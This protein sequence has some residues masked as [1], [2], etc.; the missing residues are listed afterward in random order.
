MKGQRVGEAPLPVPTDT[1]LRL[2]QIRVS[3]TGRLNLQASQQ[4]RGCCQPQSLTL[5][6]RTRTARTHTHTHAV[7]ISSV[8][9]RCHQELNTGRHKPPDQQCPPPYQLELLLLSN[10]THTHKYQCVTPHSHSYIS[11]SWSVLSPHAL[12]GTQGG[13]ETSLSSS[14]LGFRA[15]T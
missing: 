7:I 10:W 1:L 11:V 3:K 13:W 14:T 2:I 12:P 4:Y 5:H 15:V 6:T 9:T 8:Q